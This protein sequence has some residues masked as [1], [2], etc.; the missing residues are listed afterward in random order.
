M[1]LLG[2]LLARLPVRLVLAFGAALGALLWTLRIRRRVVLSNLALAFPEKTAAERREIARSTYRNLGQMVPEF[3]RIP[4]LPRAE[5]EA[6]FEVEGWDKVEGAR[7]RGKGLIACTGHYG[8]FEVLASAMTLLGTP[9]T[10]ISRKM[11]KSGA[12]DVWRGT[13][14]ASGVEDLVVK[15]GETLSAATRSIKAGRVL[16][17][18]IDQNQPRRHAIFP[19]FFGVP[20]ATAATP[21]LLAMRTGAEVIFTVSFPIGGGRHR[22]IIEGPFSPPHTGDRARDALAFMQQLN[23]RLEHWVRVH[24]DRWYWL[25]R[26]WKTRPE[27]DVGAAPPASPTAPLTRADGAR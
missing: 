7:A 21:A 18:V 26:R 10:M 20:A 23:D 22:V 19:T 14:A 9:I 24:P 1:R 17:Y 15:R 3:L 11:G 13:R 8:N 16:G 6:M 5:L 25:H 27:P 12:N 4:A 2:K